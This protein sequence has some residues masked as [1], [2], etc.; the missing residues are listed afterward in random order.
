MNSYFV[1]NNYVLSHDL[2]V[3]ARYFTVI[4]VPTPNVGE[5]RVSDSTR[6]ATKN[7]LT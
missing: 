5:T 4:Y 1:L 6:V 2:S 3:D 7:D